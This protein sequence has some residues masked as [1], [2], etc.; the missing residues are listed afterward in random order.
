MSPFEE[1]LEISNRL[2]NIQRALYLLAWDERT[3]MP[4][5]AVEGRSESKAELSRLYHERLTSEKTKRCIKKLN[6]ESKQAELDKVQKAAVR[7]MTR[8]FERKYKVPDELIEKMSKASTK[9]Q[10]AWEVARE[11]SDFEHFLPHLEKLVELKKEAAEYIGYENE[12]Y[13]AHIDEFEPGFTAEKIN[14]IFEPMKNE[15]SSIVSE[16]LSTEVKPGEGA[17]EGKKFSI[18]K[19]RDFCH[20]LAEE[21][22]YDYDHGRLDKAVH[23]FTMGMDDDVRITN[24]YS[25]ENITSIFSLMHE[26]GHALYEQGLPSDWY[27]HP[28]GRRISMG[29]HESQSRMWENFVGRSREFLDYVFPKLCEEFPKLEDVSKEEFY[30]RVN[31]V[32]PTFVRVEADE[33][34]YNLHIALRYDIELGLFR[35]E[36]EPEETKVVWENKMEEY[37][38]VRPE[39]P[40]K[41]VLQD[42]HW[43]TGQFGYFPSY[44][45]GNLYAAQ[46]FHT[47]EKEIDGLKEKI[48]EG[49]F[50]S[51]RNWSRENIHKQGRM[52]K[53]E[54]M[55]KNLTGEE[56]N[57]EY[58]IEHLEEK[59]KPIYGL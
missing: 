10:S 57:E 22:G 48:A 13:D 39:D 8:D 9:A 14:N 38:D 45:L 51:L 53:A 37:L 27:G 40:S 56:L 11:K 3:Y 6:K 29:Y 35:G 17:F 34:T 21:L 47:A 2:R 24:R 41:G 23:P 26:T 1:L 52:Y 59:Y 12:P 58:H 32:K 19:Q 4:K 18:E 42:V 20:R 46:I 15:L 31:R 55:T 43:S 7:E 54:E 50:E 16:I 28:L 30:R 5:G 25:E 49:D 33:V 36:I 44:A